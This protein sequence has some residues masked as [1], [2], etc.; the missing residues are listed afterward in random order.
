MPFFIGND[1]AHGHIYLGCN[2][3]GQLLVIVCVSG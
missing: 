1:P 3:S 2:V